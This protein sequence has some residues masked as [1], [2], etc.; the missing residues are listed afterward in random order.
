MLRRMLR[1]TAAL[2]AL[3]G[4]YAVGAEAG[5]AP[6]PLRVSAGEPDR[7]QVEAMLRRIGDRWARFYTAE[8][9][10]GLQDSLNGY[11]SGGGLWLDDSGHQVSVAGEQA[12]SPAVRAGVR[13]GDV[14]T[15]VD[16]APTTELTVA[17]VA[18]AL[19]GPPDTSVAVV[20]RRGG[21]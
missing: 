6:T 20:V 16:G 8:E 17:S 19:R 5:S 13:V 21:R 11:Y 1:W 12:R 3:A 10:G 2:A 9:F 14:I 7:A 15:S 4:A 18:A